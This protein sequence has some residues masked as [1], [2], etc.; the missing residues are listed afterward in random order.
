MLK[1][2][3]EKGKKLEFKNISGTSNIDA[4]IE[5]MNR[6]ANRYG[7]EKQKVIQDLRDV[8]PS[9]LELGYGGSHIWCANSKKERIFIIQGY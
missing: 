8:I 5:T 6:I 3:F 4:L 2:Q 9:E 7:N 1:V